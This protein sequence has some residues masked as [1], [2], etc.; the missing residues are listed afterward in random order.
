MDKLK[1]AELLVE[2]RKLFKMGIISGYEYL[3][4]INKFRELLKLPPLDKLPNN[5]FKNKNEKIFF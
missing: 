1:R 5:L 3:V 2:Y 4:E